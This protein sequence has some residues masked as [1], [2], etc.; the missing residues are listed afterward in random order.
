V[1]ALLAAAGVAVTRT[2]LVCT[3]AE[4]SAAAARIGYEEAV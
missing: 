2:E 1:A 3:A 4:A